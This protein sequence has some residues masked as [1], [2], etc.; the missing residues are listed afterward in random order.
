[1][2][3]VYL[4]SDPIQ[5]SSSQHRPTRRYPILRFDRLTDLIFHCQQRFQTTHVHTAIRPSDGELMLL[6]GTLEQPVFE[7]PVLRVKDGRAY[8]V[9]LPEYL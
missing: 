7:T 1:V 6:V 2:Y 8:L 4:T 3:P 9:E 5:L